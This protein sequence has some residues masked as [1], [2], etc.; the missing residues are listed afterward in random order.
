MD[1]TTPLLDQ[2][3]SDADLVAR[4][5]DGDATDAIAELYRR[6]GPRL[7]G[8]AL[9]RLG[10]RRQAEELVQDVFVRLWRSAR[11]YDPDLS[12][13]TTFL[14]L[15]ARR[16]VVDQ[17]RRT[18]AR[19]VTTDHELPDQPTHDEPDRTLD[20]MELRDAMRHLPDHQRETLALQLEDGLT[21]SEVAE[22][23]GV[24]LGT[25]KSRRFLALRA[26]RTH[27]EER[28]LHE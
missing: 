20:G 9:Q 15:L 8:F 13:V 1:T 4:V 16:A 11:R 22:R 27:L 7:Y 17:H 10:D 2:A 19:P 25:A 5:A 3:A 12:S 23:T 6:F 26:L 21:V 28:G 14:F 24:P 18:G